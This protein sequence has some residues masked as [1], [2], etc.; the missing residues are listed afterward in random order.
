MNIKSINGMKNA[1]L[2][3]TGSDSTH[4]KKEFAN[5]S[6][7]L[8]VGKKTWW[9][10]EVV[11]FNEEQEQ[12]ISLCK[13]ADE[14]NS[15]LIFE[16]FIDLKKEIRFLYLIK[17]HATSFRFKD[18]PLVNSKK[19]LSVLISYLELEHR[20]K[21][22][23]IKK[24]LEKKKREGKPVGNLEIGKPEGMAIRRRQLKAFKNKENKVARDRI[25]EL[26]NEGINYNQI[27]KTLNKEN[28]K[29][30]RGK[31]FYARTVMRLVEGKEKLSSKFEE[32]KKTKAEIIRFMEGKKN[33]AE[34]VRRNRELDVILHGNM[35]ARNN[36]IKVTGLDNNATFEKKIHFRF[37]D[38][39]PGKFQISIIDTDKNLVF[40]K[41]YPPNTKEIN[42]DLEKHALFGFHYLSIHAERKLRYAPFIRSVVLM[43]KSLLGEEVENQD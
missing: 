14:N 42:I 19:S 8:T 20:Q 43:K 41:D 3:L 13:K 34:T 26:V 18:L 32:D 16:S 36:Q 11:V 23:K 4:Q 5:G 24:A 17:T 37:E 31:K 33:K 10:E 29:P 25:E 22:K 39:I 38:P 12:L 7:Q 27:A 35:T 15:F 6:R 40:K 9:I 30:R 28:Y 2:V 21:S 1:I